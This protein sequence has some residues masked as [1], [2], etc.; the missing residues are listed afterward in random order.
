MTRGGEIVEVISNHPKFL[1]E[2]GRIVSILG[3]KWLK[4]MPRIHGGTKLQLEP[5][6][7][8]QRLAKFSA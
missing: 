8:D 7:M 3:A 6:A 5:G 2:N 1:Y 4:K